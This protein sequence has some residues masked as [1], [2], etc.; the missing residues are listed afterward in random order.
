M[1]RTIQRYYL[2]LILIIA[3]AACAKVS[4]PSGGSRDRTPPVVL[5]STPENGAR[6]FRG[7]R[8]EIVFDEFVVLDNINEKFMVSPPMKQKPRVYTR[9][10][11]VR[12]DYEDE[13]R[14]S[15]TYTFYFLDAI[16]DL[17]EGNIIDNYRFAFSTGPVI[18]SLSVTGNV[19]SALTLE[20]PEKTSVLLYRD[21]TDSAVVKSIPDYISRVDQTGYFRIDNVRGGTYRLYALTDDDNSKNYNRTEEAFAFLDSVVNV[22]PENNYILPQK[23]TAVAEVTK[24][25]PVKVRDLSQQSRQEEKIVPALQGDHKLTLFNAVRKSRYLTSTSRP[26]RYRMTYLLSL[27][28]DTMEF[29]LEI[30]DAPENSWFTVKSANRDTVDVWIT[31]SSLYSREIITTLVTYPFTDS[32]GLDIYKQ[33]TVPMRFVMPRT[34]K[35]Q[36]KVVTKLQ[37][38][39]NISGGMLRP[40]Q[41]VVFSAQAPLRPPD[42]TR[43]RLYEVGEKTRTSRKFEFMGDTA[44]PRR[45]H[46]NARFEEGRQYLMI[47]NDAAFGNIYGEVNDSVAMRITVREA[48]SYSSLVLTVQNCESHCIVQLL[49]RSEKLVRQEF[50]DGDATVTF[51]LLD[52]GSYR[53]RAIHDLNGDGKWTTGDFFAGRQP[54]PVTYMGK[55]LE[56]LEG[57]EA[58]EVLDMSLRNTKPQILRKASPANRR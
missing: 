25:P 46:L 33:D 58:K 53:V 14:D 2:F 23:D 39:N 57:W 49:D 35:G 3:A 37:L 48:G 26:S 54:E 44:D 36:K 1:R 18:D 24:K 20:A 10:K 41:K 45:I 13:L 6:N 50:L 15:T 28:P 4:A 51:R 29:V 34:I 9:G 56:I 7:K 16:R 42:T 5:E 32:L 30:P 17:N 22:T 19:Y 12:I 40:G 11:G 52:K 27:P 8:V 47:F 43:I 55:E 38:S 31:D 21:L